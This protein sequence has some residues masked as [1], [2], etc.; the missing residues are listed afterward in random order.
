MSEPVLVVLMSPAN[1]C[2]WCNYMLKNWDVNINAM[3]SVYPKL[4]FPKPNDETKQ[5]KY[6]PIIIQNKTI[7]SKLYPKELFNYYL[8][9]SPIVMLI[10]GESWDECNQ[11]LGPNNYK[12]FK[13]VQVMNGVSSDKYPVYNQIYDIRKPESFGT[14]IKEALNNINVSTSNDIVFFPQLLENSTFLKK[15]EDTR[16]KNILNLVSHY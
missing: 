12:K 3:L 7:D 13:N 11:Q 8:L 1:Q 6:P 4:R 10:P 9:W 2:Q 14:W 16:C 5:Y 15:I